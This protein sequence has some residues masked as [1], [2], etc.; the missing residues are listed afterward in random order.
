M[1][2]NKKSV[3]DEGMSHGNK[4]K[5]QSGLV[6]FV[7]K[8]KS[9]ELREVDR[10][11]RLA[12]PWLAA[13]LTL[14]WPIMLSCAAVLALATLSPLRECA[15]GLRSTTS[16]RLLQ[17]SKTNPSH[18]L[19]HGARIHQLMLEKEEG[20]K[21]GASEREDGEDEQQGGIESVNWGRGWGPNMDSLL[22]SKIVDE[23]AMD[24][25]SF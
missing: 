22:G 16:T 2:R 1:D 21:T 13:A 14:H 20:D 18:S 23:D 19:L 17:V 12:A 8:I 5:S 4:K 7:S 15:D 25:M 3:H 24:G 6:T 11:A 9:K 10:M